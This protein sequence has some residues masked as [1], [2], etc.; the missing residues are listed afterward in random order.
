MTH[1]P[2]TGA[3][4]WHRFSGTGFWYVCH[5]NLGPDSSGTRFRRRIEHC[6]IPRKKLACTKLRNIASNYTINIVHKLEFLLSVQCK[7]QHWIEHKITLMCLFLVPESFTP[8]TYGTITSAENWHTKMESIYST[9]YWSV[10]M[11]ISPISG[12]IRCAFASSLLHRR[13]CVF[14]FS[15]LTWLWN[16]CLVL[17]T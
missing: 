3:I 14:L 5:A 15:H 8:D 13:L 1:A 9:R 7:A 4:N 16:S 12:R 10:W 17:L 6:S 2:E 11:G